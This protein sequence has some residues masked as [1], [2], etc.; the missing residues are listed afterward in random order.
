MRAFEAQL[1]A[2]DFDNRLYEC[3]KNINGYLQQVDTAFG[4]IGRGLVPVAGAGKGITGTT[5]GG[6]TRHSDLLGLDADD[7]PNYAYLPG[8]LGGQTL[9]GS[10]STGAATPTWVDTNQ[11][12][13]QVALRQTASTTWSGIAIVTAAAAGRI[14]LLSLATHEVNPGSTPTGNSSNH[15]TITDT[16]GNTWVKLREYTGNMLGAADVVTNSLWYCIVSTGLATSDTLTVTYAISIPCQAIESRQFTS[17][18]ANPAITLAGNAA[19][20][21]DADSDPGSQTISALTSGEYLFVRGIAIHGSPGGADVNLYNVTSG[22]TEFIT[23]HNNSTIQTEGVDRLIGARG[24]FKITTG[25][26]A[27]SDPS[28][29]AATF[30]DSASI[31]L[32]LKI[33]GTV[34]GSLSLQSINA[35]EAARVRLIDQT[36]RISG[37]GDA[38]GRMV[39]FDDTSGILLSYIRASDGAFIGPIV[40]SGTD[41]HPDN[42]FRIVGSSDATKKVAFE[43]DGLTTATTRTY[44]GPD[45]DGTLALFRS[46]KLRI[47]DTTAPNHTLELIAGTTTVAPLLLTSGP[48]LTTPVGGAIELLTNVLYFTSSAGPTRQIIVQKSNATNFFVNRIPIAQ[49]GGTLIDSAS[50]TFNDSTK[51]FGVIGTIQATGA[52]AALSSQGTLAALTTVNFG[53]Q[54]KDTISKVQSDYTDTSTGTVNV[55][56]IGGLLRA[57]NASSSNANF[58]GFDGGVR[59]QGAVLTQVGVGLGAVGLRGL[60]IVNTNVTIPSVTALN[61]LV[62]LEGSTPTVTD[63]YAVAARWSLAVGTVTNGYGLYAQNP[64]GGGVLTNN[65]MCYLENPTYGGTTNWAIYSLGG[66]SVLAGRLRIGDTTA[67]THRLELVAGTTTIAPLL[68]I[69]GTSLTTPVAGV[70]EMTTDD[71]FFTITT[72]AARKAFVLDDGAR[73]TS[74]KYPKASTNG[75]LIDG[76][77]PLAG[78]KIYFVSDTSGGAVTRKLTFT[79][80]ILTS[81]T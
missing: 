79:D 45:F 38:L 36:V 4:L 11:T 28:V 42:I 21:N 46:N 43:V 23:P 32:A 61:G 68:F 73:L 14:I 5:L 39:R 53:S 75:R 29:D 44:T 3:L 74:G 41:T 25:T 78:T 7:H 48:L 64:G 51:V 35:T 16:K 58:I 20:R 54:V 17:G 69:S 76:P 47:G 33:A 26:G 70:L 52:S 8:R 66:N 37:A 19:D 2:R 77:T 57:A 80:G 60:V 67:P 10:R 31:F 9:F 13:I 18:V 59:V 27:T 12:F 56:G 34:T 62:Y 6:V 40:A 72:G 49:T 65:Y 55:V 71:L 63:A 50:L 1:P 30:P 15:L 22:F 81:E 24:E